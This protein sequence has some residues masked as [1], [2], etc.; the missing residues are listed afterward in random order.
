MKTSKEPKNLCERCGSRRSLKAVALKAGSQAR[1]F[2]LC[3]PC[4]QGVKAAL[5]IK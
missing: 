2:A 1:V 5:E 3:R 4:T